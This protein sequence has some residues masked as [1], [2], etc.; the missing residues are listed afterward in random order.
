MNFNVILY[1]GDNVESDIFR[2]ERLINLTEADQAL[3]NAYSR[4]SVDNETAR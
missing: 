4:Q 2:D 1:N 3:P